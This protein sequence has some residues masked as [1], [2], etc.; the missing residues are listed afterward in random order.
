M[1]VQAVASSQQTL[2]YRVRRARLEDT[3]A[4]ADL[5]SE[6]FG[7]G[8]FPGFEDNEVI[9]QVEARYALAVGRE[10]SDKLAE[11]LASKAEAALAHRTYRATREAAMLTGQLRMAQG[12]PASFPTEGPTELRQLAK[13]RRARS[14]VCL[15]VEE[16]GAAADGANGAAAADGTNGSAA[17]AD[18]AGQPGRLLGTATLS[19]MQAEAALPPPFPSSAPL[20]SY[21]SNMAVL[22]AARRQ[23]IATALVGAC[24][25]IGQGLSATNEQLG[26]NAA[27]TATEFDTFEDLLAL[28]TTG[29]RGRG[30]RSGSSNLGSSFREARDFEQLQTSVYY[31]GGS[32]PVY[33][34][35]N[36]SQT[37]GGLNY[38]PY[39]REQGSCNSCVGQAVAAAVQMSL[40]YTTREPVDKFNVSA[41]ALY[42]CVAGG[43]TCKTGWDIPAALRSLEVTPQWMLPRKCFDAALQSNSAG[44]A[45]PDISDFAGICRATAA[46][47]K[48]PECAAVTKEQPRYSCSFKSLSSF[49]QVQ[50]HIRTHGSVITRIAVY[51]DF[52]VQFNS[53]ARF[54]TAMELPPYSRN[55]TAKLQYG[56][57]AV[58]V[59]FNNTEYTWTVLNSWGSGTDPSNP[60]KTGGVTADGMFKIRMGVA[61]VGTP[62]LTYGVVCEPAPG[63]VDNMHANSPWLKK[64][65]LP[66]K[67]FEKEEGC[68]SYTMTASDTFASVA[69]HFDVD[70]RSLVS[71][72]LE[73]FSIITNTTYKYQ[74]TLSLDEMKD[75]LRVVQNVTQGLLGDANAPGA[76]GGAIEPHFI[77]TFF[78]ASGKGTP[79]KCDKAT[80]ES[81][82]TTCTRNGTVACSLFYSDVNVTQPAPGSVIR[83]C[84]PDWSDDIDLFNEVAYEQGTGI[85]RLIPEKQEVALRRVLQVIDPALTDAEASRLITCSSLEPNTD[86]ALRRTITTR[87]RVH[88]SLAIGCS[89]NEA[90][91]DVIGLYFRVLS[92]AGSVFPK[93][94]P[95]LNE[96]LVL[97][98]LDLP[99]LYWLYIYVYGGQVA[100]QLGALG[101][102]YFSVNHYCMVGQ[103]PP[104]LLY[105]WPNL[106]TLFVTRQ[107]DALDYNDPAI[108]ICGISGPIPQQWRNTTRKDVATE[109]PNFLS[110]INLSGNLLSGSLPEIIGGNGVIFNLRNLQLQRN[111]FTGRVPE[112]WSKLQPENDQGKPTPITTINIQQNQLEG[113]LPVSLSSLEQR[114]EYL[115]LDGNSQLSGCVPLT[116]Y[117]TV[118]FTGTQ[119]AGRC[120]G[121]SAKDLMHKQQRQ[122]IS[123]YFLQAL[124]VN[125]DRDFRF[126]L[127]AVVTEINNTL[128]ASVQPGQVSKTFQQNHPQGEQRGFCKVSVAL[129]DGIEYI[130]GI[131]VGATDQNYPAAGLNMR[132]LLPM[133]QQLPR[134]KVLDCRSCYLASEGPIRLTNRL[135]D[136][137]PSVAPNLAKLALT[138]CGLVG[139]V[140]RSY[141]NWTN[142]EELFL[143]ANFL[144]GRLPSELAKLK[145]LKVLFLA[146]NGFNGALPAA[147][148]ALPKELYVGLDLNTNIAGTIPSAFASNTGTFYNLFNTSITGCVPPG[149]LGNFATWRPLPNGGFSTRDLPSCR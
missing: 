35:F 87:S 1:P 89:N 10:S 95:N 4:V 115:Y 43:R 63:S 139:P 37:P 58:I 62:D 23:G 64:T 50:Q 16:V 91:G 57:A 79:V 5:Y 94:H 123:T 143:D 148:S 85:Y 102:S 49:W 72:N 97:A 2:Q 15:L 137:L 100:P 28:S 68:Y 116:P 106:R 107:G 146:S 114:L 131:E 36:T 61:G 26:A 98:L 11:A 21:I 65:R 45:E 81:N 8:N 60:R 74:T 33:N 48:D 70:I 67:P 34:S 24:G 118:T 75:T 147:W 56:H 133:L 93:M 129:I 101:L 59:G 42:Y 140:P 125:V 3:Q 127:R 132:R 54:K 9:Q 17:A 80:L 20:R 144:S 84:N 12:L 136:T 53:S 55:T 13:W 30:S 18:K 78:D 39:P 31:V 138:R 73:L 40:A 122:A 51:D 149:L 112:A 22:P 38:V 7:A 19:L 29:G 69:D 128:G 71:N 77:C 25:R 96:Q 52:N 6:V 66:L 32:L 117:T 47:S 44:A 130:T 134:L 126:M 110:D 113:P 141:G 41:G 86:W 142:M 111:R 119:V 109:L 82:P 99:E 83:V 46:G 27:A 145:Q 104:N 14:F 121:S 105:G 88:F 135:P 92:R 90:G 103:L 108:G 124:G 120:A 76:G